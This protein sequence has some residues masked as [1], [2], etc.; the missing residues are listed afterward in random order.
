MLLGIVL[1]LVLLDVLVL[2]I[3]SVSVVSLV[4]IGVRRRSEW[5]SLLLIGIVLICIIL[6]SARYVWCC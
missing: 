4:S 3:V 1:G 6:L 5:W 2:D